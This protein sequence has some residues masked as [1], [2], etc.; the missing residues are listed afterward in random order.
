MELWTSDGTA[1]G[2]S[3]VMDITPGA[4]G[5][6]PAHLARV[7]GRLWFA[8]ADGAT[9]SRAWSTDG[10]THGT[11]IER[12]PAPPGGVAS[13]FTA[14][15]DGV[16]FVAGDGRGNERLWRRAADGSVQMIGAPLE[17]RLR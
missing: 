17:N 3:M 12:H 14:W 1:E 10:S 11:R 4:T 2:T 7:N 6:S 13:R 9:G 5:S 8:A 16:A 15:G